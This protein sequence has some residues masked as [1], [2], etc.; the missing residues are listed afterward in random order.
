MNKKKVKKIDR[1]SFKMQIPQDQFKV[2][3]PKSEDID[4]IF[5]SWLKSY[6]M[7]S[8]AQSVRDTTYYLYHENLIRSIMSYEG[9]T[10]TI[11]CDT[12]DEDHILA[13]MVH[14]NNAPIIQY[15]YVKYPMRGYGLARYMLALIQ[16]HFKIEK[17]DSIIC[18]HLPKSGWR[19]LSRKYN[20][21]YNPYIL[22]ALKNEEESQKE[23]EEGQV[24]QE[25][26]QEV[27]E[28]IQETKE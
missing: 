11:L 20:L 22:G 14:S 26:S 1:K 21:E 27:V 18:T 9:N 7:S 2:R 24:T 13:Y 8:Y 4:F 25:S 3:L 10:I 12:E 23:H 28:E 6:R 5:N 16:T 17:K 19:E 15:M